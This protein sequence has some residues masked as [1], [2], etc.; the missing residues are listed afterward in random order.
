L[1]SLRTGKARAA[2]TESARFYDAL[3]HFKDYAAAANQL[4]EIIQKRLPG[5]EAFWMSGVEL[6][7]TSKYCRNGMGWQA[8]I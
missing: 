1:A 8:P 5:L 6:G 3:Y 4:H 7:D 2:Y